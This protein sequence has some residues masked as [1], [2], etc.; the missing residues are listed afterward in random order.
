[1]IA[2]V[3]AVVLGVVLLACRTLSAR[4]GVPAPVLQLVCGLLVGF[5]PALRDVHLPAE[6]VLL[7]FLPVLLY[8][9]SL[10]IGLRGVRENLRLSSL[11]A[12]VLVALTAAAVAVTGHALGLAWGPAWVLGAVLAP[13]D[14]TAV[15]VLARALPA[16]TVTTL[17]TESLVNDG[18]ALVLYGVAVAATVHGTAVGPGGLLGRF[19]LSFGGGLAAGLLTAWA[20][21]Q[22]RRR[23]SDALTQNLNSLVTP[24]VAYLLAEAVHASGVVAVVVAGLIALRA[25]PRYST[26]DARQQRDAFWSL[27]TYVLNGSLFVLIGLEAQ[28]AAR[29]LGHGHE[30]RAVLTTLAVA[31]AVFGTRLLWFLVTP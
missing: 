22:V 30:T 11:L 3:L 10:T 1:V 2:L 24:F 14:A 28:S 23:T 9:E 12:T 31:G 13:T 27:A 15:A 19:A 18:T 7:L 26:A 21:N 20:S 5:V 6:V 8:W 17:R 4:T 16:R 29:A 25:V